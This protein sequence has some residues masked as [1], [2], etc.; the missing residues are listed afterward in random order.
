MRWRDVPFWINESQ[1]GWP[2]ECAQIKPNR[3][4][5]DEDALNRTQSKKHPAC[6][7]MVAFPPDCQQAHADAE[8]KK[9][10]D[11][12]QTPLINRLFLQPKNQEQ[13]RRQRTGCCLGRKRQHVKY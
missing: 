6:T 5:G 3:A 11:L 10:N 7:L 13:R 2:D 4:T 9:R 1:I 8:D 12:A